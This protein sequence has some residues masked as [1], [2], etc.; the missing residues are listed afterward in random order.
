MSVSYLS[1]HANINQQHKNYEFNSEKQIY[2]VSVV[3]LPFPSATIILPQICTRASLI[4]VSL[5]LRQQEFFSADIQATWYESAG[6]EVGKLQE[7]EQ[8]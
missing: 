5:S 8:T 4:C 6:K 1:D 2:V 7:A 3:W